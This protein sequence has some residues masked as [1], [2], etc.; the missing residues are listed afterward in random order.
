[1]TSY[2]I[3]K[4]GRGSIVEWN[5]EQGIVQSYRYQANDDLYWVRILWSDGIEAEIP[6]DDCEELTLADITIDQ[7]FKEN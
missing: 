6:A 2:E 7:N 4:H 1:M 5:G 3:I